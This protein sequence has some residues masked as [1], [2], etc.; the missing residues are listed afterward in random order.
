MQ[1]SRDNVV[2]GFRLCLA[3]D[4]ASKCLQLSLCNDRSI[5]SLVFLPGSLEPQE[6]TLWGGTERQPLSRLEDSIAQW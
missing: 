2:K 3:H 1:V 4:G 6:G 5:M